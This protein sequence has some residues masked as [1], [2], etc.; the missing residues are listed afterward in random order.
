M[1][2][3]DI[4]KIVYDAVNDAFPLLEMATV[5]HIGNMY[6]IIWTNDAGWIPHFH[7][8]NNQNPKKSTFDACIKLETP[9]YFKHGQHIDIL[10]RKQIKQLIKLLESEKS[11][12]ITWW[13]YI[14]ESWNSNNS[15][16]TVPYDMPMPDY[17][18]LNTP[19]EYVSD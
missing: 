5:G 8:F 12:G 1:K 15:M 16:F 14:I 3:K 17:N 2:T 6:L 11:P 4:A 7:V 9:E 18:L 19:Y 10:S 13:R